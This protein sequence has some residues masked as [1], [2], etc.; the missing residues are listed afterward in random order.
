MNGESSYRRFLQGDSN[1]L[2]VL[3]ETYN[4]SL[5]FYLNGILGNISVAED[6][7]AD[8]FV[9][10]LV[11]KPDLEDDGAFRA[12][13]FRAGRNRAFDM[14]RKESK[15]GEAL[16]DSAADEADTETL[17]DAFLISERDK[18][19]HSAI[20]SLKADYRD[21]LNLLYFH[22]ASYKDA[23]LIMHKS[24][25]QITNLAH[26]AKAALKNSLKEKGYDY[27]NR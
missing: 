10:I 24:E 2:G 16:T 18:E 17:E 20:S 6:A 9:R 5:V 13:L 11:K 12:Y 21:V 15:H 8:A 7:A 26:R 1:A 25:K 27:E 23:A 14:L 19:I 22:N 4:K 3:V